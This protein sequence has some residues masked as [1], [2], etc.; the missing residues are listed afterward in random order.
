MGQGWHGLR[1]RLLCGSRKDATLK[2]HL[3]LGGEVDITTPSELQSALEA[4]S[5]SL[6]GRMTQKGTRVIPKRVTTSEVATT[7]KTAVLDLGGPPSGSVWSVVGML[8]TGAD[9]RTAIGGGALCA[10]YIGMANSGAAPPLGGLLFPG[11]AVPAE[12]TWTKGGFWVLEGQNL[13]VNVYSAT[14]GQVLAAIATIL[15]YPVSEVRMMM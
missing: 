12:K 7:G 3:N 8:V 10:G 6:V 14:T 11:T 2:F 13:F 9:D 1:T 15:Q 5:D 4:Q